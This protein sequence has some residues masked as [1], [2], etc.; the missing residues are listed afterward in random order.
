MDKSTTVKLLV[1]L[2]A[3]AAFPL[4]TA[5]ETPRFAWIEGESPAAA[6]F[7]YDVQDSALFSGGKRLHVGLKKELVARGVP[8]GG[9]VLKYEF[10]AQVQ[11]SYDLWLR[12]GFE[13]IRAPIDWRVD[14]GKWQT[15][16]ADVPETSLTEVWT[17]NGVGWCRPGTVD[18][19]E[20]DHTL[21]IR[22]TNA[23]TDGRLLLALDCATLVRGRWNPELA[24]KPGQT[25][26][27]P[28]D[29]R[30]LAKVFQFPGPPATA[31]TG[32]PEVELTGLWQ[33]A[34]YDDTAMDTDTFKPVGALPINNEYTF[35]WMGIDVPGDAKAKRPELKFANRLLYRTNVK[36]PSEYAGRGFVLHFG[37]TSYI[38]AVFV[39]G[40]YCGGRKSVLVPW[41][42]DISSAVRPGAVNVI[43]VAIKTFRYAFD[44]TGRGGKSVQAMQHF[45]SAVFRNV[46]FTDAIFPSTKGEGP[47]DATGL[48]FPVTLRVTGPQYTSD[49]YIRT[50]VAGKN[51]TVDVEVTNSARTARTVD[52]TCEA[53]DDK[54]GKVAKA[55]GAAKITVAAGATAKTQ[56][57]AAWADAKLWWPE[58][59]ANVYRMRTTLSDGKETVDVREDTFGFRELTWEGRHTL[60]NGIRWHFW[61]WV[62]VGPAESDEQWLANYEAENNRFHRISHDHSRRFGHREKA[63]E[64]LDRQGIPGRLS[65]CIDGMFI[66]HNL[67]NP[68]TWKNFQDHVRQ[69]VL[70]YRNHPSIIQWSL[71]NEMVLI[72]GRLRF[73]RVYNAIEQE[74]AKLSG[75]AA[76]LD[77]TRRSYQDGGGDLGGLIP[78]NCQHY[79][80]VRGSGFPAKAYAYQV[81]DKP[82]LPRGSGSF[83]DIYQWNGRTPL[84]LGEVFYHAGDVGKVAWVGGPGVYRGKPQAD[85]AAAKY[86]RIAIEGA[87]W[88][89]ATGICPWVRGLGG[90]SRSFAERAVFVKEHNVCF[91]G[92]TVLSR[93]IGVFNDGRRAQPLT[94]RWT[95]GAYSIMAASGKKTYNIQPGRH[96][97]DTIR[98]DLPSVTQ[99]TDYTLSLQVLAGGRS[100]F[101]D[102]KPIS[103]LPKAPAPRGAAGL[104][105]YDPE[106]SAAR[107]LTARDMTYEKLADLKAIP[108]GTK[109]LL[110][111]TNAL[112]ESGKPTAAP[113]L[114]QFV[115]AGNTA[116]VLDQTFP[117]VGKDLPLEA[118][119][120]SR[121]KDRKA[122]WAEFKA[123]GGGG[124]SIAHPVARAHPVLKGIGVN[125]MFTWARGGLIYRFPHETPAMG[126]VPIVQAGPQLSQAPIIEIPVGSGSYLLCQMMLAQNFRVE[127]TADWLMHNILAWAG[128]RGSAR[129]G[130]TMLFD[131]GDKALAAYL[132]GLG[133]KYARAAGATN[134]LAAGVGVAVVRGRQKAIAKLAAS[135]DAVRAFCYKGGW[136]MVANLDADALDS[137]N[138]LV[139]F[140]HRIRPGRTERITLANPDDALLMGVS[141]RDVAQYGTQMVAAWMKLYRVSDK[142][143]TRVV[144]GSDVASFGECRYPKIANGLTNDDFWHYVQYLNGDGETVDIEYDRIET[145]T[146]FSIWSN[147]SY[148]FMKDVELVFDGK[149]AQAARFQLKPA[150]GKQTFAITPPRRARKVSIV[151][152]T[153]WPRPSCKKNLMG[154]DNI[155]LYR[156]LPA[157]AAVVPL[158]RPGGLM[159]YPIGP[160]GIVLNQVDTTERYTEPADRRKQRDARNIAD[161]VRKKQ[162]I[163]SSL[164][165]NMGATFAQPPAASSRP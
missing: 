92:G 40:K 89:D 93:T 133:V 31:V 47:G 101:T 112:A 12:V 150:K 145:F 38:A 78:M 49:A 2:L 48:V 116:I 64:F 53:V 136:L 117:L 39:N 119:K 28:V 65:T 120:L 63:L 110:I 21:E 44:P 80:W 10:A 99:R 6:N 11:G 88:Q 161:N 142:V 8:A 147:P 97:E 41:D 59:N 67:E 35:R 121:T 55:V 17:W 134:A 159:K 94:V 106:G 155:E 129:R 58:R 18:L 157:G 72:T 14:D 151:A 85:A 27:K 140:A 132:D 86:V 91:Y 95:L 46:A 56:L 156:K 22:V 141:D 114:K 84:V 70:A 5:A 71:G 37:G 102:T 83:Q 113:L 124:S 96:V 79:T 137:F 154:I 135:R 51:I 68:I 1:I 52:V 105:V 131:A 36:V 163:Y 45:P 160:G 66:T 4:G 122:S 62:D 128:K 164:L 73:R 109:I 15:L 139:G 130:R 19:A 75:I 118:I 82:V 16:P 146:R 143:F 125:D 20:G 149:T 7:K 148:F 138:T 158:S 50:S 115:A 144:D 127:P 54:T 126:T 13:T 108:D 74:S 33:V 25:Y 162:S 87:R 29:H 76:E 32:R 61:N 153:H 107:W 24:F 90:A 69:V 104:A 30:A 43:V 26:D 23:G 111:G 77:P 60:L 100:V 123:A 152:R 98:I 34:R 42:C 103:I 165:R 57:S 9:M 3:L 81:D